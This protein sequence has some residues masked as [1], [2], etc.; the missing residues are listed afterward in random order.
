MERGI[1]SGE[2]D[3][4]MVSYN[5]LNDELVDER[6]LPLA[7]EM[8]VGVIA[9]KPLAGGFLA[10]P[11]PELLMKSRI[12]INAE[13][14]LKFVLSNDDVATAIPGMMR[15]EEVEENVRIG[16]SFTSMS[17]DERRA[18]VEAV[19]SISREF[20]RGCGYCQ[21]CPQGIPIP[22]ILRQLAYYKS[23]GLTSWAKSRY[24]MVEVKASSCI[25]CGQCVRKCPYELNIP[26]MLR[27]AHTLL[28]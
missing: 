19:E 11:P 20:C 16:E 24:R 4:I 22:I 15:I 12:P 28:S 9:M 21:P 23:Y 3:V 6:I 18:L 5:I 13:T 27:E 1:R 17:V 25:G 2:F 8:D 14:A 26:E 7:R 10:S